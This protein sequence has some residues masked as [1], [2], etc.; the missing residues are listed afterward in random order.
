MKFFV[1]DKVNEKI[2]INEESILLT[3]E[4]EALW[5]GKRNKVKGDTTGK[6]HTL[7]LKELKY[8]YLYLDWGSPYFQFN[9]KDKHKEAL[10]DS[11]LT[12]KEF[13]D[14]L[15]RAA[16]NKYED[17]QNSSRIGKLLK[18]SYDTIDKI[19]N[20]LDTL[21]LTERDEVTGK[22]IFKT[23]DVIAEIGSASK[24]IDAIKT[25]EL[26]FKKEA[27]A[28]KNLRGDRAPGMFD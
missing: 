16:A 25:L 5:D 11:G 13:N 18:A 27:E 9:E 1:Y 21:D 24:L 17:L 19:T 26:S 22:P 12:E 6:E 20:Y 15:F 14:P 8:I 2:L 28:D 7:A 23:K 3:R 10:L 4:F